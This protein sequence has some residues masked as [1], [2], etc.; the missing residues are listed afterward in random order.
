MGRT[1]PSFRYVLAA[2]RAEWKPFRNALD[3]K[4]KKDFDEMWDIPRNYV[5]ACSNSV[6]L[7]PLHP[8]VMSILLH[9]YKD[10]KE[11]ISEVEQI[12]V[13]AN[14]SRKKREWT[15]FHHIKNLS[16]RWGI[17]MKNKDKDKGRQMM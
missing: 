14:N 8:I 17:R 6:Q 4:E 9:H 5:S 1:V 12:E 7:V 2:E 13:T 3:K 15:N 16:H 10:L 11:C